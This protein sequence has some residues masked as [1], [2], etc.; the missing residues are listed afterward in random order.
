MTRQVREQGYT[1]LAVG[2]GDCDCDCEDCEA[3]ADADLGPAFAYTIGLP[4]SANHPELVVS[5]LG[6]Q[7]MRAMLHE[8]AQRVLE[9]FRFRPGTT[10]ENL[11]GYWPVVADPMS[12]FGLAQTVLWSQD[13]HR[14][15]VPAL[16]LVWPSTSGVFPWQPGGSRQVAD[17]QPQTWRLPQERRGAVAVDPP[18]PYPVPADHLVMTCRHVSDE[19]APV[20]TVA[21]QRGVDGSELWGFLC[22]NPFHDPDADLG[23]EHFAHLARRMPSLLEIADLRLGD[24]ADRT[25]CWSPWVRGRVLAA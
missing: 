1:V 15:Q 21:R 16:Q 24:L 23:L 8:A 14:G 19:G 3:D 9:G 13:F 2:T 22:P 25:N 4:H 6:E 11:I 5:G 17:A 18:W 10:A 7:L 20:L 12:E